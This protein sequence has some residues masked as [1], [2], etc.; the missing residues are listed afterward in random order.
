MTRY[1]GCDATR[2]LIEAFLDGQLTVGDQVAVESHLRWCG[3]CAG[4]L[5][6]LR[7][8]GESL[9]LGTPGLDPEDLGVLAALQSG[10]LERVRAEHD[11]SWPARFGSLFEDMRLLWPALGASAALAGCLVASMSVMQAATSGN[12]ESLAALI[13]RLERPS[14]PLLT[15]AS[16]GSD[17]NPLRLDN[18]VSFPRPLDGIQALESLSED[19]V[20]FAV[21]AVVTREGRISAYSLLDSADRRHGV[22]PSRREAGELLAVLDGVRRSRFTPAEA[23]GGT[24]VAVN[25]IWLLVRTTAEVPPPVTVR[26]SPAPPEPESPDEI[27]TQPSHPATELPDVASASA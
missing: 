6:D 3:S 8:V 12:P 1:L 13:E 22:S 10:V 14:A 7:A 26:E 25:M 21:S 20:V 17:H 27:V 15:P 5:E 16:P 9:R 11:Q 2:A 23:A 4:D 19:E 18:R 24:K